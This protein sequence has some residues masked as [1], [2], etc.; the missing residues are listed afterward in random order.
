MNFVQIGEGLL[1]NLDHVTGVEKDGKK[2]RIYIELGTSMPSEVPF[3][4]LRQV[5]ALKTY[6]A[7]KMG[8]YLKQIAENQTIPTP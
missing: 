2:T 1:V 7:E 4:T 8:K 5:I 3:E 6:N